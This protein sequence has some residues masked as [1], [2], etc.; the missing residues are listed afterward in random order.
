MVVNDPVEAL[1]DFE[2]A[3][4]DLL[5]IDIRMPKMNGFDLFRELRKIDSEVKM[6]FFTAFE[7]YL[8]EFHKSFPELSSDCFLRKPMPIA[9]F[10]ASIKALIGE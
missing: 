1:S 4:Y 2:A 7:V 5:I 3:A 8:E 10:A 6:C 9:E